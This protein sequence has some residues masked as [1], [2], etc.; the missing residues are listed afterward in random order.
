MGCLGLVVFLYGFYREMIN[1]TVTYIILHISGIFFCLFCEKTYI[2]SRIFCKYTL[3]LKIAFK[4]RID[5]IVWLR[6]MMLQ[7][8]FI[9]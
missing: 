7:N 4:F 6:E 5:N 8:S 1:E 3:L 9:M 2:E